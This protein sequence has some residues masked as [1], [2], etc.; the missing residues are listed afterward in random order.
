MSQVVLSGVLVCAADAQ[1]AT[2]QRLLG[3]HIELTR[4]ELG[5][6]SFT[7][8]QT[9]DPYVWQV[10]EVFTDEAAFSRHQERALASEWGQ[11]TAGIERRY[12]VEGLNAGEL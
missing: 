12:T 7:V 10:D 1:V 9:A 3:R 6:V 8:E 5:C 11:G 4:A 2:V